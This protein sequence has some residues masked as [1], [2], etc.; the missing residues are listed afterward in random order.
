MIPRKRREAIMQEMLWPL[1]LRFIL[2]QIM[3]KETGE[4]DEQ[5][6]GQKSN[7]DRIKE[8]MGQKSNLDRIKETMGQKSN[9]DR[10]KETIGCLM[11]L[12][13]IIDHGPEIKP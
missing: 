2:Q 10:I 7:L 13:L 3:S 1:L 11:Y 8:T 6:M 12:V 9:F 5:T 4:L